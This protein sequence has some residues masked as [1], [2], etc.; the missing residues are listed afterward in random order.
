MRSADLV[1]RGGDAMLESGRAARDIAIREGRITALGRDAT[2]AVA[3][4]VVDAHGLIVLPGLVD[5]HVHFNEPGR[6]HWEGWEAGTRGAAAGGVTTVLEMPLNA[7]PPTITAADFDTKQAVAARSALVDFGLWGGL[8][9]DNRPQLEDL[10]RRGVVAFKA[11]MSESGVDDFK[12]VSGEVLASAL[13][14]TARLGTVVGVHAESNELTQELAQRLRAAGRVDRR[15]WEES[16]P[17]AAELDA[18]AR[19]MA[20]ASGAGDGARVHVVHVSAAEGLDRVRAAC[21]TGVSATAETCPHYLAFIDDDF[22][23]IGPALKCTPPIR[24]AA[25]RDRLWKGLL[26]GNVDVVGSDHSPCPAADK[27]KGDHDVWRAWGGVS[28]VQTMLAVML[29]EGIHG[30]GLTWEQLVA[31]TSTTPAK[32]FGLYPRKGA[33]RIGADADLTLVDPDREWTLSAHDL[34]T[35]SGIS[36]YVGRRFRGAVVRTIVRGRTV[37]CDGEITGEPGYGRLVRRK[38]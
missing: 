6:A 33:I 23:Q 34:Q 9:D 19:L 38:A 7:S 17:P 30:R 1:I 22:D 29:T 10:H 4:D 37:Y 31:L 27:E 24:D 5:S 8:V 36:P 25:N 21:A 11:F 28:G 16:R 18:I 35:R 32:L 2:E 26:A 3:A 12:R 15:A 13:E 14:I 20:F